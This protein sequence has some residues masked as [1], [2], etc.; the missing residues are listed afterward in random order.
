MININN[1]APVLIPT[2]NRFEHFKKCV[3]SLSKNTHAQQTELYIAL[4]APLGPE[5]KEGYDKTV[6][7]LDKL[8][9]FKKIT[10]IKRSENLGA[11]RNIFN[12]IDELFKQYD[13]II[14]SEDDNYFSPNFLD[15]MNK[16]LQ[17]FKDRKDIFA[18]CGYN[19][20]IDIPESYQYNLYL[21]KMCPAWG[22]GLWKDK[23]YSIDLSVNSVRDFLK[24][25]KNVVKMCWS[26]K[27]LLPKLFDIVE[28]NR[29]AGD[30][31][32]TMNLIN[33]NMFCVLP[34]ISK[35]RN[36]GYDGTGVHC[37]IDT[38]GI[39]KNQVID[40]NDFF[41]YPNTD[42]IISNKEINLIL[43]NKYNISNTEAFKRIIL[44]L[45]RNTNFHKHYKKLK[46]YFLSFFN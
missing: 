32:F 17:I 9:G 15:Y 38:K 10:I 29:V 14:L 43:K 24:H 45:V 6:E 41:N 34:I 5:H 11:T 26:N 23:Y 16:G 1:F 33:R 4:D 46:K 19:Y 13:Q 44:Y 27:S 42:K 2:L 8:S 7:Y 25:Y 3:D 35:V 37:H 36:Y 31:V 28:K 18:I 12:S 21:S 30:A 40:S 22:I 39:Y 20:P